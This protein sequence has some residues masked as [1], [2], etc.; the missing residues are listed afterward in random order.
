MYLKRQVFYNNKWQDVEYLPSSWCGNSY[1]N[2]YIKPNEYW[3]FIAP[4]TAGKI[5]AKFRF[6]LSVNSNSTIYSNEFTGS[7]N[8]SQLK[9]EQGYKPIGIMDPYTN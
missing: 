4:C 8:K 1:H 6:K 9:H 2:V 7:F 3:D 5:E